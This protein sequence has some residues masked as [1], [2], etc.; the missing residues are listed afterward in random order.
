MT[1]QGKKLQH[2]VSRCRSSD[3]WVL[4]ASSLDE[5]KTLSG[6]FLSCFL[7]ILFYVEIYCDIALYLS[8]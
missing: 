8:E 6:E 1:K 4:N 5:R 3:E 2:R 7:I